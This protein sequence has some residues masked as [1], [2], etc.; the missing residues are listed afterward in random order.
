MKPHPDDVHLGHE[1]G[2]GLIERIRTSSLAGDDQ[3]LLVKR[4]EI[5]FWLTLALQETKISL[6]RLERA[7]LGEGESRPPPTEG[8]SGGAGG[9]GPSAAGGGDSPAAPAEPTA[10]AATA[11][12]PDPAPA[13]TDPKPPR[14]GHGREGAEAYTGAAEVICQLDGLAAGQRCPACDRGTLYP[15]PTGVEIRI[16][17]HALLSAVRYELEKLR[18]S[19]CGEVFTAPLPA[20][21]GEEK[22]SSQ[23]RAVR[24]LGRY[25]LGLP[26]YRIEPFQAL[27]GVPVADAT[28]WDC[29]EHV[30]DC[31]YPVFETLLTLAAQGEVI[32]QDDTHVRILAL[33]AEKQKAEAAGQPLARSGMPTTGLVIEPESHVICLYFSGRAHAGENLAA[34]L[35]RRE[36]DRNQPLVMSDALAAHHLDDET[37]V[38]RSHCLAHG[39]R[40]FTDIDEVFPAECEHALTVLDPVFAHD[41]TALQEKMTAADRLAY[42]PTPSRP[43]LTELKSWME[44]Q[45][46]DRLVE[47]NSRLGKAFPYL[48]KHW[49]PLTR[50]LTVPGVPIDNRLVSR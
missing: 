47:P 14:P 48:L 32:Y 22:Y 44:A 24:A 43:R 38:I 28:Q 6:K 23:A 8:E 35:S 45:F 17:S 37:A 10:T 49:E 19:A 26:F 46:A 40:A 13:A 27:V 12:V 20:A 1:D 7:L 31:A 21:A 5:Y 3:R 36:V 41:A 34:L 33:L 50:F 11:A 16:D 4:I 18:C 29:V 42:H 15:L 39:R 2:Q 25:F 30:A 9:S